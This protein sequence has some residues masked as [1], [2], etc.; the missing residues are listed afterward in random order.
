MEPMYWLLIFVVLLVIEIL[1]IG[2][3]TIWFAG[4]ALAAFLVGIAGM[5]IVAQVVIFIFVSLVLLF[6][7][8]PIA[9][10]FFNKDRE[11]TNVE[12]L[13]GQQAV[14]T[15]DIDTLQAKGVVVVNGL[16]WSAKTSEPNGFIPKDTV[17]VIEEIQGVKL[18]VRK[19]EA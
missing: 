10:R 5:G 14:V 8:R 7:T 13:I 17:V 9:V 4:G 19:K 2:L 6:L 11:K 12:S 15:E 16:E 18:I 3:T 1:T